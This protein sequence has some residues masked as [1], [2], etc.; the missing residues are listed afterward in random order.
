MNE[1]ASHPSGRGEAPPGSGHSG[2]SASSG[3]SGARYG[4]DRRAPSYRDSQE[5]LALSIARAVKLGLPAPDSEEVIRESVEKA[6]IAEARQNEELLAYIRAA[7]LGCVAAVAI[8]AYFSPFV[9]R[10]PSFPPWPMLWAVLAMAVAA[11]FALLLRRGWYDRWLTRTVPWMDGAGI[12]AGFVLLERSLDPFSDRTAPLGS[13][14]AAAVACAFL[15]VSGSLRLSK[16]AARLATGV[17]VLAWLG[18][19]E[20]GDLPLTAG[21]FITGLIVAM[22][23]LAGRVT[24]IIRGVIKDEVLR[25]RLLELYRNAQE[26]ID[27]REGVLRIVSHDLRNPLGTIAMAADL[28]LETPTTE[29]QRARHLRIIK[30]QGE[31]MKRLVNDLLDAARLESGRMIVSPSATRIEELMEGV[32]EMMRPLAEERRLHLHTMMPGDLPPVWVD[33][34]RICQ[35]FSNLIGNAIKFTPEGGHIT[36]KGQR[37]GPK[38]RLSV[39]DTGP[40]IPPEQLS[41]IF[42][43]MWQARKDDG[44]GIGLGLTIAKAIVEAHGERIGVDSRVGEGTEFWFTVP[45]VGESAAGSGS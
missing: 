41:R 10:L 11:G 9:F 36:L 1:P 23:W 31:H 33:Y 30:R 42:E 5:A 20:L 17:A 4:A 34:E 43:Q 15:A 8:L 13:F 35:V 16:P 2:D 21:L 26:A 32:L 44:R 45:T 38:V 24:R 28:L 29:Q 14:S 19:S 37:L 40:G 27:A 7:V 12:V 3:S 39:A 22:G 18:V 6:L 25:I